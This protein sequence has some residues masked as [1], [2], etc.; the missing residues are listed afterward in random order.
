MVRQH[1]L[2]TKSMC[3]TKMHTRINPY[4]ETTAVTEATARAKKC[5]HGFL[6]RYSL[7]EDRIR[8]TIIILVD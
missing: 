2:T 7:R 4:T 1:P 6:V 5:L 8:R 3:G